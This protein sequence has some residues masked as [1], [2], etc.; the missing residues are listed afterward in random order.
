MQKN[1][2]LVKTIKKK[3]TTSYT[4]KKLKKNIKYYFKIRSYKTISGY[5]A[6]GRYSKVKSVKTR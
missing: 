5:T 6:Y 3:S 2:K 1:H 4:T